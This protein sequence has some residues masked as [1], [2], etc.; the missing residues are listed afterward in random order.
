MKSFVVR[1]VVGFVVLSAATVAAQVV[2]AGSP[3]DPL[4]VRLQ[5]E[6]GSLGL[7]TEVLDVDL[8]ILSYLDL[9]ALARAR[10]AAVILGASR[11]GEEMVVVVIDR[12]TGKITYRG[13]AIPPS[14]S[15]DRARLLAVRALELLRVS[16]R[17]AELGSPPPAEAERLP[18]PPAL[19]SFAEPSPARTT[20]GIGAATM[21]SPGG[22]GPSWG[23]ALSLRHRPVPEVALGFVTL[24]PLTASRT[25]SEAGSAEV[26]L[27]SVAGELRYRPLGDRVIAPDLGLSAGAL[28]ATMR[29]EASDPFIGRRD[30]VVVFVTT[31]VAGLELALGP[32]IGL[33]VDGGLGVT[34]PEVGVILGTSRTATWGRPLGHVAL[35]LGVGL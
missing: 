26:R 14:A 16:L 22:L 21:L 32:R 27:T 12:V 11:V 23:V 4:V 18:A 25:S 7:S 35:T 13:L 2:V 29:G 33:R 19:T 3:S 20:L 34:L 6:L 1:L 17:E 24:A 10:G 31:L 15:G 30:A 9:R 28:I 8:G 5:D